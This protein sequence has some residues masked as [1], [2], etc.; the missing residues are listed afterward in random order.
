MGKKIELKVELKKESG[1]RKNS[2]KIGASFEQRIQKVLDELRE[3]KVG[4]IV[5]IPTQM[6]LIRGAGGRIVSAFPVPQEERGYHCLL[7][8]H[9]ILKSGKTICIEAKSCA[10]KTSFPLDNIKPYQLPLL[11]ELMDYGA[12]GYFIIEMRGVERTFLF[13]GYKFIEYV[14]GLERK[15]IPV[16]DMEEIGIELDNDLKG[17]KNI[18]NLLTNDNK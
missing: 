7:D 9:G 16:K 2:N 5:K 13:E 8:F 17:L 18:I 11:K 3:E 14:N 6:K 15:S 1:K 12:L 4:Y 10:N